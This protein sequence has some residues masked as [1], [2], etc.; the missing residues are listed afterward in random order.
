MLSAP[1]FWVATMLVFVFAVQL[2]WVPALGYVSF[3]HS[4]SGWARSM[5]L[6]AVSLALVGGAEMARQLRTGLVEVAQA[7]YLRAAQARGL[8]QRRVIGK[9]A[10]K[11]AAMPALTIVGLR[12]G[13]LL[14]GAVIIEQIFGFPGL[15]SYALQGIQNRDYPVI[16]GVVLAVASIIIVV[17]L[18]T[19]VG[20]AWLNPKVRL[21]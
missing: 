15:G 5:V 1:S 9:H 8:S 6:P 17:N 20:Y 19:D 21:A 2:H 14:A 7:D 16:Q 13:Y 3:A 10:L 12:V 18:I 11:N 4:P